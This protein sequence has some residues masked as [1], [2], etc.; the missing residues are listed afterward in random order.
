MTFQINNELDFNSFRVLFV[1]TNFPEYKNR[2]FNSLIESGGTLTVITVGGEDFGTR[3][4]KFWSS[5]CQKNKQVFS[6]I[7]S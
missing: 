4:D 3:Y 5:E 1:C 2:L 7:G 6:V